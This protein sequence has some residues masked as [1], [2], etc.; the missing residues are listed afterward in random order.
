MGERL[1]EGLEVDVLAATLRQGLDRSG[2]LLEFLAMKFEGPLS[3]L[4]SVKRRGG[5]FAK[6]HP[7]EELVIRFEERHF[8]MT[9]EPQGF[10]SAKILKSVRGVVLKTSKVA[11]EDWLKELAGELAA[12]A[13][14]STSARE[15]LSRFV[16]G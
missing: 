5:L 10:L 9:R 7:I 4:M 6:A 3:P 14:R 13:E 12:Q 1:I 8:Q 16:L 15:A 11:E 2:D